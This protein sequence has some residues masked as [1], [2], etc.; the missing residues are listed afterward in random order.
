MKRWERSQNI[1]MKNRGHKKSQ[2]IIGRPQRLLIFFQRNCPQNAY[3]PR[4]AHWVE[5]SSICFF[6][7]N[8]S[9]K[10]F[11][12]QIEG[13][14]IIAEVLSEIYDPLFYPKKMMPPPLDLSK[15]KCNDET[16]LYLPYL[17][18]PIYV[19]GNVILQK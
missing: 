19:H 11:D 7:S 18:L 9:H 15:I 13:H 4:Y 6:K 10:I 5:E 16:L 3:F 8:E 12:H 17:K 14:K 1:F 2:E